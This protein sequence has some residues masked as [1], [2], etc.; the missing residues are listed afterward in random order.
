M[1]LGEE[2]LRLLSRYSN[3]MFGNPGTTELPML[4][5]LK[6]FKYYLTLFD[7]LAVGMAEGYHLKTGR[8]GISNLHASPGLANSLGFT[9]TALINR[10]PLLIITGQQNS[11]NLADE[12]ILYHDMSK[13]TS[14]TKSFIEVRNSGE[15]MK[16]LNK[17]IRIS[18]TPP[19]GPV[20][21]SLPYDLIDEEVKEIKISEMNVSNACDD[22]L[23][24]EVAERINKS[25]KVAII[26]GYEVEIFDAFNELE[27]FSKKINAP[28]YSEPYASRKVANRVDSIIPRNFASEVNQVLKSYDLVLLIGGNISNIVYYDEDIEGDNVIEV[29]GDPEEATKRHW[30]TFLCNP[31]SFLAKLNGLVKEKEREKVIVKPDKKLTGLGKE[32]MVTKAL[33]YL[34]S[35]TQ[36]FAVFEEAPSHREKVRELIGLNADRFYSSRTGML[37]W[38]L[39]ASVGYSIAGGSALLIIGDGS[40][41]YTPHSLW[42]LRRYGGRLKILVLNNEGYASLKVRA[43]FES[44]LFSPK[45]KPWET[46]SSYGIEA[47]E[48]EDHVKAINWL[49]EDDSPKLAD[50]KLV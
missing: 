21:Y 32:E 2:V 4:K 9:Y 33:S 1:K 28:I 10:S 15:A 20:V 36:G 8:L 34:S 31:K 48:F 41:N 6:G 5:Y 39:P 30:E 14:V 46:A 44:E 47:R 17:A 35:K 19:F 27:E 24:K 13:I 26:A 50:L 49:F 43:G 3:A 12:P 45:T 38:A 40:F 16:L 29:T 23:V 18:L 7:G 25:N 22:N 37:G 11:R 42:T